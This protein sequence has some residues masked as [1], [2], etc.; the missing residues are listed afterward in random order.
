MVQGALIIL[1]STPSVFLYQLILYQCFD[2][3]DGRKFTGEIYRNESSSVLPLQGKENENGLRMSMEKQQGRGQ[4]QTVHR[5]RRFR[6]L[7]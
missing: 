2:L 5:H 3:Q 7:N 6:R 4:T 1:L